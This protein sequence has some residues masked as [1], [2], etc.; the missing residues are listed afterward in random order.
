MRFAECGSLA[1]RVNDF[2][3]DP[4]AAAKLIANVADALMHAHERGSAASRHQT[5]EHPP[6]RAR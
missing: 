4:R 1:E 2:Q 5:L 6:R 3:Y